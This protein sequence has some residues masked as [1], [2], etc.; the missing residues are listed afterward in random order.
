MKRAHPRRLTA[1]P[2]AEGAIHSGS[3]GRAPRKS[4]DAPTRGF[5]RYFV[6]L[7]PQ[8]QRHRPLALLV[9]L[10]D[11]S[12]DPAAEE[13]SLIQ[14]RLI[15]RRFILVLT[16]GIVA[17]LA[18]AGTTLVTSAAPQSPGITA[19]GFSLTGS[20]AGGVK[21]A[22]Y[23]DPLTFVFTEVNVGSGSPSED[24]VLESLTNASVVSIS[25][26]V[27]TNHALINPD[28]NF[29]EP[30]PVS[31]GQKASSVINASITGA[32]GSV[33]ARVC[34]MNEGTGVVGPCTN[35]SVTI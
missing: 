11:G 2:V 26:V 23:G 16:M 9:S 10:Y 17:G 19:N 31:H 25:C 15:M 30:G 5:A 6:A 14:G 35:V 20:T 27:G 7:L 21:L 22:A 34:L 33:T 29:C 28:G 12:Y 1:A 13:D 4:S 3:S 24:L 32:S 8:S 18:F